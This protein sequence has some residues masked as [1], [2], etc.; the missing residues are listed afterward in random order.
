MTNKLVKNLEVLLTDRSFKSR[1]GY[2]RV[3]T[4]GCLLV[5]GAKEAMLCT[6]IIEYMNRNTSRLV[7]CLGL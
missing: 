2:N 7:T 3:R 1:A 6:I 5:Y 4:V